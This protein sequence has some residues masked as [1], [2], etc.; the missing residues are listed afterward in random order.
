MKLH[1]LY[2]TYSKYTTDHILIVGI[3]S[4]P[5]LKNKWIKYLSRFDKYNQTLLPPQTRPAENVK[6]MWGA[7]KKFQYSDFFLTEGNESKT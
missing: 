1:S 6:K 5:L 4:I 2:I 3:L 7:V